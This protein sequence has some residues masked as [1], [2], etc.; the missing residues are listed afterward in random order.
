MGTPGYVVDIDSITLERRR[1]KFR[2]EK[3][4]QLTFSNARPDTQ[5]KANKRVALHSSRISVP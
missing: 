2:T 5:D 1:V 4:K 3:S